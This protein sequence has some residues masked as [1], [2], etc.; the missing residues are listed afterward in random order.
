MDATICQEGEDPGKF[1]LN[2]EKYQVFS[3]EHI[4]VEMPI[5]YPSVGVQQAAGVA[6]Q[7][8]PREVWLEISI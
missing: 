4:I 2:P 3:F 7:S 5:R 1:S 8:F 6:E